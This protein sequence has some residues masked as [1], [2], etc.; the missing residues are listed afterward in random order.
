M[1]NLINQLFF[2]VLISSATSTLLFFVW[3]LLRGFF[4]IANAKLVYITLRFISLMYIFPVGYAAILLTYRTGYQGRAGVWK[5]V[6][7]RTGEMSENL[8]VYSLF[9]AITVTFL[10]AYQVNDRLQWRRKLADN[11]PEYDPVAVREYKMVCKKL[12]VKERKLPLN[13]NVDID[14]PCVIGWIRPRLLLPERDYSKEEL[15]LIFYH[16]LSHRKH[17]DLGFKAISVFVMMIHCFNPASWILVRK[18]NLW[19]ECMADLEALETSGS[20]QN[21]KAYFDNIARLIPDDKK[22]QANS[23]FIS[24]LCLDKKMIDRRVDFV[25]KYK[26]MKSAGRLVTAALGLAFI[27]ASGTTAY[28]SGKT[29]ADLHNAVYQDTENYASVVDESKVRTVI[30]DDGMIEYHCRI[31]DLDTEGLQIITAPDEDIV[32]FAAGVHYNMDWYV[33]PNCRYVS[34]EYYVTTNQRLMASVTVTPGDKYFDL[35]IM[36]DHGNAYYVRSKGAASHVFS[37]PESCRYR[38]FVQNNNSSTTLH[39]TGYFAYENK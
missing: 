13:R 35:G 16:E 39:A 7:A 21:A 9:W 2:A 10:I 32:S 26:L 38:A 11:L 12:K 1:M 17:N 14:M 18:I 4:M 29:V 3:W 8:W 15:D 33:D 19:S 22:T 25:K 5:L 20:L 27:F 24:A 6:F 36:D 37:I 34:G 31:E 23:I 28:A 30:A